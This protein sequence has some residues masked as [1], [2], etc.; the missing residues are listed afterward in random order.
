MSTHSD[1]QNG[2]TRGD[3]PL[4]TPLQYGVFLTIFIML[5]FL[6]NVKLIARAESSDAELKTWSFI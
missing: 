2:S 4:T 6:L 1:D 3:V 5:L